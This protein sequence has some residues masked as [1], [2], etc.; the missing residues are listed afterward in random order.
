VGF[1]RDE[2]DEWGEVGREKGGKIIEKERLGWAGLGWEG[3]EREG[4]I[5]TLKAPS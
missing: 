1:S 5:G 2:W 3:K 4:P